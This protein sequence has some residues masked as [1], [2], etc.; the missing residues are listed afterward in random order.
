MPVAAIGAIAAPIIGGIMGNERA[1]SERDAATQARAD[2]LAQYANIDL[3]DVEKMRLALEE[4]QTAG[5]YNPLLEQLIQ[6]D[7]T[8]LEQIQVDP[9]LKA[10]QMQA[11]ESIA[12]F[13]SGQPS[14]ADMAGFELARR[15]AAGEAQ[16]KQ[17]QILQEMQAR[18]QGG[19]GAELIAKMQS[20]QKGADRLAQM[21]MEEAKA[22]QQ[23][24]LQALAQQANMAGNVRQQDYG[25]QS[26]LAKARDLISQFNAQNAQSVQQRNV[27]SQNQGQQLN[28]GNKQ[29]LLNANVDTRNKQ[30]IAN[31]NLLQQQYQNQM[32]LA[33]NKAGQMGNIAGAADAQAGQTAG[34]WAGIG[35]GVGTGISALANKSQNKKIFGPE[36]EF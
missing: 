34:M 36:D 10:N 15:G 16:A 9:R 2:A 32:Q 11:L 26:D 25:E 19:S 14:S 24:R 1:R 35:Q 18:G 3:P 29:N 31:K 8:A 6:M 12:G 20:A 7:P 30:Q 28:L 27:G 17:E 21:Q 5:E 33:G 4:Y 22:M 23:A 13:A